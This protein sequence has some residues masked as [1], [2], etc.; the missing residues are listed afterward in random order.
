ML[1]GIFRE[2]SPP[3]KLTVTGT[4]VAFSF[5]LVAIVSLLIL[6]LGATL[7]IGM[8][9]NPITNEFI[10]AH[11]NTFKFLQLLQ[12]FGLFVIPPF[13]IAYLVGNSTTQYLQLRGSSSAYAYLLAPLLIVAS[14]PFINY[15]SALNEGL[16]LPASMKSL[17]NLMKESEQNADMLTQT[18]IHAGNL[19]VLAFNLF[20]IALLP[21]IGEELLFRGI[22]LRQFAEWTRSQHAGVWISAFIFSFIHFQFYGFLPRL[23]LGALLGYTFIFTGS[24][25]VPILAHFSNNAMA[26]IF[27]YLY[28]AGKIKNT[29]DEIGAQP[30]DFYKAFLSL[31]LLAGLMIL[32][33][34]S[35]NQ[36]EKIRRGEGKPAQKY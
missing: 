32:L 27:Y 15:L 20:M 26:V 17:E 34:H 9:S 2:A 6:K 7:D 12:S 29:A 25:W 21:A 10:A 30:G 33:Y 18:F 8:V 31:I 3:A 4:V 14:I 5:A 36:G 23:V 22:L 1:K 11:V 16:R 19:K 24:L 28:D 13:L 35:G